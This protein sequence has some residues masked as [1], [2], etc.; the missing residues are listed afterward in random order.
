MST[1]LSC[2]GISARLPWSFDN[3]LDW[4]NSNNSASYSYSKSFTD[5][6]GVNQ[7]DRIY[8]KQNTLAA[9]AVTGGLVR[10]YSIPAAGAPTAKPVT[11]VG[12]GRVVDT[13][14]RRRNALTEDYVFAT[15]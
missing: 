2:S 8:V 3:V 6:T 10:I 15:V 9:S 4:A 12:I 1:T 13:Q 14:R 7:A 5:G 11:R